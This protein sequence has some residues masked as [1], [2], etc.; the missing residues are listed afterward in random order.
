VDDLRAL[1]ATEEH[2]WAVVMRIIKWLQYLGI[3]NTAR[4]NCPPTRKPGAW[5]GAVFRVYLREIL[6]TVT[7]EKWD[8]AK[9]EI[10]ELD[11]S[12]GAKLE[13]NSTVNY[14]QLETIRG[15]MCHIGQT[16]TIVMPFLK[17]FHLT[18]SSHLPGRNLEGWKLG[19]RT[20]RVYQ[21]DRVD[22]GELLQEEVDA[23][24]AGADPD[25]EPPQRIKPVPR[26]YL[27]LVALS[28]F[29]SGDKPLE[30][31]VRSKNVKVLLYG[32][33][34]ASGRGFGSTVLTP[35]GVRYRTGTWGPDDEGESS[36]W[37]EFGNVV[38]TVDCEAAEG[39]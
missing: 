38:E 6:K 21:Q 27:D 9:M 28:F 1:G 10:G 24:H 13:D 3:Q 14:K 7:Q 4:K 36:N 31:S 25:R 16:F 8:K 34:D 30:V 15:F 32:F 18:L 11:E 19:D 5:A 12:M 22:R 2:A 39:T 23:E 35:H 20:W 33:G 29:F 26:L 17:G 37:K